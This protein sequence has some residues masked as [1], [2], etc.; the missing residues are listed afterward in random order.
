MSST[1]RTA[2]GSA[3]PARARRRCAARLEELLARAGRLDRAV[4]QQLLVHV[5][6]IEGDE[7]LGELGAE[8][9]DLGEHIGH[10]HHVAHREARVHLRM[11]G[12]QMSR[13][14]VSTV[15]SCRPRLTM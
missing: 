8:G 15:S 2:R 14:I 5:A 11:S 7:V 1:S 4:Q 10:V 3:P 6:G 12:R 9:V 13:N